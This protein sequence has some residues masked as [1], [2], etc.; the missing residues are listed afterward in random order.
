MT[1]TGS[2]HTRAVRN[3]RRR[4]VSRPVVITVSPTSEEDPV[5]PLAMLSQSAQG[6]HSCLGEAR[7][8]GHHSPLC[9]TRNKH[10]WPERLQGTR[11]RRELCR[12]ATF[13]SRSREV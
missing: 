7:E 13:A 2:R 1:S 12:L 3:W 11:E 6:S 9:D 5:K 10:V 8:F 4:R